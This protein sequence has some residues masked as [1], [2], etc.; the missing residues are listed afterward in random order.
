MQCLDIVIHGLVLNL[1]DGVS[2][3]FG[4]FTAEHV[5]CTAMMT[6]RRPFVGKVLVLF[7]LLCPV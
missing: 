5:L 3:D 6:S 1:A 4:C 2:V 7:T